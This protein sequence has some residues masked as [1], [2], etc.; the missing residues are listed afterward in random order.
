MADTESITKDSF[1]WIEW[2]PR[3]SSVGDPTTLW[4]ICLQDS[5]CGNYQVNNGGILRWKTLGLVAHISVFFINRQYRND[6]MIPKGLEY[7]MK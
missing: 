5:A 2:S 3:F 7:K 1:S 6:E 4:N